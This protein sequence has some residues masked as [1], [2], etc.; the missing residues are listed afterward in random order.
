MIARFTAIGLLLLALA[1]AAACGTA[2]RSP[3]E[4]LEQRLARL[5]Q[6]A[7]AEGTVVLYS[8]L[9]TEDAQKILPKFEGRFPRVKVDHLRASSE[10]IAQRIVTERKAGQD[11][12][13]VVETNSLDVA[14]LID[15]GYTQ[16]YRVAAWDDFPV[17]SK[18]PNARWMADR[19]NNNLPGLN[20]TKVPAGAVK[21]WKDLCDKKYAGHIAV[22]KGDVP[23]YIALKRIQGKEEAQRII[24]CIAANKPVLQSGHTEMA[25]RLAAGEFWAT[26]SSNGH[27]LAQLKYER[28]APVDWARTEPVITDMQLMA[29]ASRPPHPNAARLFMEWLASPPG[30]QAIADTGRV[31]ASTRVKVKYP[32]LMGSARIFFIDPGLEADY[33]TDAA[34]WRTSFG[35]P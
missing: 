6:A 32:D 27:R 11:L 1:P 3:S 22:E 33:N 30:Q 17:A 14:F 5:Y 12:F 8:S 16:R 18:D 24:G 15:Q 7:R 25:N 21:T 23:V 31:P 9:N 28:N 13:D 20:A 10:Q 35:I 2:A 26:F 4:M 19:L 29:L 34:F